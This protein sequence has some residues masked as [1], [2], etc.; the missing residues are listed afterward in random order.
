[1]AA[2]PP[3]EA[4]ELLEDEDMYRA[5]HRAISALTTHRRKQVKDV[6]DDVISKD[7]IAVQDMW[8]TGQ[9]VVA[10]RAAQRNTTSAGSASSGGMPKVSSLL[11][12]RRDG[13][14]H[15]KF[16][17][18][19][20]RENSERARG[21]LHSIEPDS[22]D[23]V[24]LMK[25]IFGLDGDDGAAAETEEMEGVS[26]TQ[27]AK[28]K[29]SESFVKR[30]RGLWA[31]GRREDIEKLEE[32]MAHKAEYLKKKL[33]LMNKNMDA[34]LRSGKGR[35]DTGQLK[36]AVYRD[37][38]TGAVIQARDDAE[39][40]LEELKQLMDDMR[41]YMGSSHEKPLDFIGFNARST[42]QTRPGVRHAQLLR[43]IV[44]RARREDSAMQRRREE[45]AK[46]WEDLHESLAKKGPLARQQARER[47]ERQEL[48]RKACMEWLIFL[49]IR[50]AAYTMYTKLTFGRMMILR[51]NAAAR[52]ILRYCR[53]WRDKMQR[54]TRAGKR[55][56]KFLR[57][58]MRAKQ[59]AK[60]IHLDPSADRVLKFL[61]DFAEF[62]KVVPAIY[63][64]KRKVMVM[65]RCI[66]RFLVRQRETNIY[67]EAQ[68]RIMEAK[69]IRLLMRE[70]RKQLHEEAGPRLGRPKLGGGRGDPESLSEDSVP[71]FFLP[72]SV[73][74]QQ[75]KTYIRR[76]RIEYMD[77]LAGYHAQVVEY[78][79]QREQRAML[80]MRIAEFTGETDWIK[81]D[82]ITTNLA[83]KKLALVPRPKKVVYSDRVTEWE[84]R[85]L[86]YSAV[87]EHGNHTLKTLYEEFGDTLKR[88]HAATFA[89]NAQKKAANRQGG[90]AGLPGMEDDDGSL[91]SIGK[92][93]ALQTHK[94]AKLK[95]K[96]EKQ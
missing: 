69:E 40:F 84:L 42:W 87:G 76:K 25:A 16:L 33:R 23:D 88:K 78:R 82:N 28:V 43:S 51:R 74:R 80:N 2:S 41:V 3:N 21:L 89:V 17:K 92:W 67:N 1:M 55:I 13:P 59:V 93:A 68:W 36:R 77:A 72:E 60:S 85:D 14:N 45:E 95:S 30:T 11:S 24:E 94:E 44:D 79:A 53:L 47:A 71:H 38:R 10:A 56:A 70:K 31:T 73:M 4:S 19:S 35:D 90:W 9:A 32:S 66:R 61:R 12:A 6:W 52:K 48:E 64:Y 18:T 91:A 22:L 83:D 29:R 57:G 39:P 58:G 5:S 86:W 50:T 63:N 8:A 81:V 62:A 37:T 65:Q 96:G 7:V 27:K 54:R 15:K 75:L 49:H 46:T 34:W 20:I 26:E